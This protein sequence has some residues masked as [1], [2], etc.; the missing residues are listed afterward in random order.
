MLDIFKEDAKRDI[1]GMR[2]DFYDQTLKNF[3]YL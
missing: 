2:L 1:G 3:K